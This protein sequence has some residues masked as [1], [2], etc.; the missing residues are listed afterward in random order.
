[1]QDD[2]VYPTISLLQ[3]NIE[4]R[5]ILLFLAASL[6]ITGKLYS[7]SVGPILEHDSTIDTWYSCQ[8]PF[9]GPPPSPELPP[10]SSWAVVVVQLAAAV[11]AVVVAVAAAAVFQPPITKMLL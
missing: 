3:C 1:M 11:A 10:F 8:Q 5:Y 2:E 9:S 6:C 7:I 4:F